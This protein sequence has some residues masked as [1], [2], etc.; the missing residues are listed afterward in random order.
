MHIGGSKINLE[1]VVALF[2][3]DGKCMHVELRESPQ[4][5]VKVRW[6]EN[7]SGH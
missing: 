6:W 1:G 2:F 7:E 3:E 4:C 5:N